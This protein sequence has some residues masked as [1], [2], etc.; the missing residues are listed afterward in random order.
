MNTVVVRNWT[1]RILVVDDDHDTV[2]GLAILLRHF[3]YDARVAYSGA[4]AIALNDSFAP[5]VVMLDIAMPDIS[6]Y[7]VARLIRQRDP[8]RYIVAATGYASEADRDRAI[9]A[10]FDAHLAKPMTSDQLLRVLKQCGA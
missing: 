8:D 7:E 6:G 9:R 5:H 2:D 4:E 1:H 3:G 10:G